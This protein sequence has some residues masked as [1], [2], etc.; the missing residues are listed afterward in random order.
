MDATR[1]GARLLPRAAHNWPTG[2]PSAAR[3]RRHNV[4]FN[5]IAPNFVDNGTYLPVEVQADPQF[6]ERLQPEVPLGRLVGA[7]DDA[8]FAAYLCS[9]AANWFFGPVFAVGGGGVQK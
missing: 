1:S 8:E 9:E 2:R 3:R 6:Q 7:A 4:Q 5:A